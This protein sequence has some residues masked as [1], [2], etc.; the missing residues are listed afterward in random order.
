MIGNIVD[1]SAFE[2]AEPARIET[3]LPVIVNVA[4]A[5]AAEGHAHLAAAA[6][7]LAGQGR[8]VTVMCLGDDIRWPDAAAEVHE[9]IAKAGVDVRLLGDV[10][11]PRPYLAAAD[12][13]V[14]ASVAEGLSNSLLEAMAAGRLDA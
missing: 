7:L 8:P 4:I 13:V 11:D 5:A 3:N 2:R 10:P 12:V 9:L 14:Q 1:T 6:Q